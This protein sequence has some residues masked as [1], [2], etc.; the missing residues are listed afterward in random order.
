MA[1]WEWN[2][3][4][5]GR[6][7]W[8]LLRIEG[9][10]G[11]HFRRRRP[12]SRRRALPLFSST[13]AFALQLRKI[14]E[15]L[16]QGSRIATG[17][18]IAQTSLYF[19]G[20]PRLAC[21]TSVHLGYPGDY[22]QPSVGTSVFQVAGIRGSPRQLTWVETRSQCSNVVGEEWDRQILVTLPVTEVPRCVSRNA[23]TL[24]V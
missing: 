11:N 20:Q 21:W 7:G 12:W 1:S 3:K 10:W 22:S 16:T 15:N 23:K 17:L 24:G 4:W 13:L 2:P 18:L 19:E 6:F 5:W 8:R 14:K 9:G